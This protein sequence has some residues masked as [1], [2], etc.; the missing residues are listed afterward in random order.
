M[1]KLYLHV[2]SFEELDYRQKILLQPDTMEYNRGYNLDV[3]NYNN[4]TGCIDFRK[5][6]WKDWYSIWISHEPQRYYAYLTQIEDQRLF[7]LPRINR[8]NCHMRNPIFLL[9]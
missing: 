1:N 6:Y 5:E 2:P 8:S 3:K 9:K 7:L 4:V